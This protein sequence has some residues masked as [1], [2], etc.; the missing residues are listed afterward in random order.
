MAMMETPSER[1]TAGRVDTFRGKR[2]YIRAA[3]LLAAAPLMPV[4][5]SLRFFM[6]K[7]TAHPGQWTLIGRSFAPA[8]GEEIVADL[9]LTFRDRVEKW[10]FLVDTTRLI[11][12]RSADIDEQS[13]SAGIEISDDQS[14]VTMSCEFNIWEYMVASAR[15]GGLLFFPG[16]EWLFAYVSAKCELIPASIEGRQLRMR[17]GRSRGKFIELEARIEDALIGTIGVCRRP[18]SP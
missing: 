12:K 15:V 1:R 17:M 18:P 2:D 9:G 13:L 3:D 8:T 4:P 7:L 14:A 10:G 6:H 11:E 5:V 16:E